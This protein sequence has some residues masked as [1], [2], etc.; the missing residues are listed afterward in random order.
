MGA[1]RIRRRPVFDSVYCEGA[2]G[3]A[4]RRFMTVFLLPTGGTWSVLEWRHAEMI[5][6]AVDR[7]TA[8]KRLTARYFRA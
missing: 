4:R 7:R 5:G 1:K 2:R 6:S 8:A 3:P